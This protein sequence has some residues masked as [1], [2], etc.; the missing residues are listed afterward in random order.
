[1]RWY[2]VAIRLGLLGL[3][4][5]FRR[6][7]RTPEHP[8]VPAQNDGEPA[9]AMRLRVILSADLAGEEGTFAVRWAPDAP[10]RSYLEIVNR[11]SGMTIHEELASGTLRFWRGGAGKTMHDAGYLLAEE[12]SEAVR[13]ALLQRLLT[14][15]ERIPADGMSVVQLVD[16]VRQELTPQA[17][18]IQVRAAE[19]PYDA[20]PRPG[21]YYHVVLEADLE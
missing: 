13:Q 21:P 8:A 4:L 6:F 5:L 11:R 17:F 16:R 10:Y 1:M 3:P 20:S 9:P 12:E 7:R 18:N 2:L 14:L 19:I 15:A